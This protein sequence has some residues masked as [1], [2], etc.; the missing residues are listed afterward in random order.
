MIEIPEH[1]LWD[2]DTTNIKTW[3]DTTHNHFWFSLERSKD[4]A[5]KYYSILDDGRIVR[6]T[7][8]WVSRNDELIPKGSTY[9]GTGFSH[10]V[11][12]K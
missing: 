10:H 1:L 5:D 11:K 3:G 4:S 7:H 9:L 12:Y 6:I 2:G 8:R